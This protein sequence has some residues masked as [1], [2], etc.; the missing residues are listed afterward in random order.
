MVEKYF[1]CWLEHYLWLN[2]LN[3][4]KMILDSQNVSFISKCIS[5]YAFKCMVL[6]VVFH[7]DL[8][9]YCISHCMCHLHSQKKKTFESRKK[10]ASYGIVTYTVHFEAFLFLSLINF[11]LK[12]ISYKFHLQNAFFVKWDLFW[13][14]TT[15]KL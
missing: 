15:S 12:C 13:C 6:L 10:S 8:D 3:C 4:G 1:G 14:E 2:G 5:F 9:H 11:S 7:S